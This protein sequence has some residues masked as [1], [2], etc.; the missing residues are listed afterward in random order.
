MSRVQRTPAAEKDLD[1]IFDYIAVVDQRPETA[2]KLLRDIDEKC[3]TYAAN[4]LMGAPRPELG[5]HYRSFTHKRYVII[6]TPIEGGIE[7][8][9]VIDG[10]RDYPSLFKS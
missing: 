2:A 8:R 6:Y 3:R 5:N 4:P 1:D 9:A 7:I 10:A